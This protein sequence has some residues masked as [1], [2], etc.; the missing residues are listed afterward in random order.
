MLVDY[1][2]LRTSRELLD[3]SRAKGNLPTAES[4]PSIGWSAIISW[5][6]GSVVGLTI[7]QGIPS[8]NS[9][10]IASII[11]WMICVV[12]KTFLNKKVLEKINQ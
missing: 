11:Y 10:L 5:I 7:E 12:R 2:I 9:L 3:I 1:Y 6:A 4:T 8:L